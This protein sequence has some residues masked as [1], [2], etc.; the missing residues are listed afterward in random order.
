MQWNTYQDLPNSELLRGFGHVDW[1]PLPGGGHG[2]PGD[3]AEVRA[4]LLVKAQAGGAS[5]DVEARI[6]WWLEEGGDE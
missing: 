3:V 6:D 2:N 1:L 5:A 4:D